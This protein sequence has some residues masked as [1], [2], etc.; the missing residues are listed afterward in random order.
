MESKIGRIV[1]NYCGGWGY[2][3]RAS[4]VQEAVE[5]NFPSKFD[6]VLLRDKGVTGRLE[7][8]VYIGDDTEGKLVHSKKKGDGFVTLKNYYDFVNKVGALVKD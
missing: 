2:Y 8:T 7:V 4:F 5:N 3:P 6:I 1:V